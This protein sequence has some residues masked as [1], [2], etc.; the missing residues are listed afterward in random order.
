MVLDTFWVPKE[1]EGVRQKLAKKEQKPNEVEEDH[2]GRW[3]EVNLECLG[4]RSA[5]KMAS[6][7]VFSEESKTNNLWRWYVS[8][9]MGLLKLSC[10]AFSVK[11]SAKLSFS[12][13]NH[14]ENIQHCGNNGRPLKS[15]KDS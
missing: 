6:H 9:N 15:W 2:A 7:L 14:R 3:I 4:T 1:I 8:D 10:L 5:E 11:H 13:G 12:Q